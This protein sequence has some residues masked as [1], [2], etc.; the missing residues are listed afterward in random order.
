[1][2]NRRHTFARRMAARRAIALLTGSHASLG[3]ADRMTG[4]DGF[5]AGLPTPADTGKDEPK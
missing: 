1:M 2:T 4:F 5:R 3:L